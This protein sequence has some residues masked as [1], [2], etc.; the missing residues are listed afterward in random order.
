MS[1]ATS[2]ALTSRSRT[3]TSPEALL[4][5]KYDRMLRIIAEENTKALSGVDPQKISIAA[6][7]RGPLMKTYM[8]R[9]ARGEMKWSLTAF[10]TQAY[11]QDADMSL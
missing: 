5:Q 11:A 2:M 10:P 9:T 1:I 3:F 8:E 4:Y 6:K 7:A